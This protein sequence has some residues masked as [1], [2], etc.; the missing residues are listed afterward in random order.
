LLRALVVA[1]LG[2]A[3]AGAQSIDPSTLEG[4]VLLGYQGWFRCPGG[5]T[6][7]SNW[8]HW[9]NGVPAAASILIDT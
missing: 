8:S 9:A 3:L 4:E 2:S 1:L 6:T 5:G 7:G